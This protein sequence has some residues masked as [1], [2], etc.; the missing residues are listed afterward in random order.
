[1]SRVLE[2]ENVHTYIGDS[3][4]LHGVSLHVEAG[5][6]TAILGRNGVGKTTL[7][8][9]IVGFSR[10]RHGRVIFKGREVQQMAAHRI[11]HMGIGLVPQ[12]RRIFPSLT[13]QEQILLGARKGGSWTLDRIY[14]LFPRL[15]ERKQNLGGMLSGGEQSMLAISRALMTSPD[16]LVMDEPSEGLAPVVIQD[17]KRTFRE[18]KD[19]GLTLLLVE[20]NL[21]LALSVADVVYIMSKGQ[22]VHEGPAAELEEDS[23]LRRQ[24]LGV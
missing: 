1:M 9:S 24:Y 22:V 8:R 17:L 6:V 16:V 15:S 14:E 4:I 3:H 13:V 20:Q 19:A 21:S 23:A 2:V 10:P 7:I 12:G 11:C 18:L 5:K